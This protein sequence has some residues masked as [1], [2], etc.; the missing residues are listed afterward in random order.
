MS[1]PGS[2]VLDFIALAGSGAALKTRDRRAVT[3]IAIDAA[4]GTIR[5][6]IAMEGELTWRRDGGFTGAP[7]GL[8]GKVAGPLDLAPPHVAQETPKR[9]SLQDAL[10][11]G[12][13]KH[14]APFCCD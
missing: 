5:G 4:A 12:D 13:A 14:R 3:L 6:S 8:N 11:D 2:T 10:N 1:D 7:L 9:A